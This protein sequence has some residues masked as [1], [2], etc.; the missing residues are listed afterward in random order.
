MALDIVLS[1]VADMPESPS[2]C[3]IEG[4]FTLCYGAGLLETELEQT[5]RVVKDRTGLT[6]RAIRQD[7]QQFQAETTQ[8]RDAEFE[9]DDV[10]ER[11]RKLAERLLLQPDLLDVMIE[12]A[13]RRVVGERKTLGILEL[14]LVSRLS[15]EPINVAVKGKSSSGKSLTVQRV[16]ALHP[17][18]AYYD[19]TAMSEKA[20][21]YSD[22]DLRHRFL[23]LFEAQGGEDAAYLIRSL[24]TEGEIRYLTTVKEKDQLISKEIVQPGPTGLITTTTRFRGIEDNETRMWS[25]YVRDNL[26]RTLDVLDAAAQAA[27]SPAG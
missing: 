9:S 18:A 22:V 10:P 11:V 26:E 2:R 5:W 14:A 4:L 17:E 27:A 13:G 12:A 7:W 15:S 19:L 8:A 3:D 24:L 23:V 25:L 21:V 20:L 1:N 6:L 16:L